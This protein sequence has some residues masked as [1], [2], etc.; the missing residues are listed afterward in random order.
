MTWFSETHTSSGAGKRAGLIVCVS[1]VSVYQAATSASR[2]ATAIHGPGA[3]PAGARPEAPCGSVRSI[4]ELLQL[5][6]AVDHAHE[7]VADEGPRSRGLGDGAGA[8]HE[9]S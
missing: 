3:R 6:I 5:R 9:F 7:L 8:F 4:G 2:V 1:V